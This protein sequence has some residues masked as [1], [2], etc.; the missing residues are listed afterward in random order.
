MTPGEIRARR[1]AREHEL[2]FRAWESWALCIGSGGHGRRRRDV[3]VRMGGEVFHLALRR[4]LPQPNTDVVLDPDSPLGVE[5]RE[6]LSLR[7][8]IRRRR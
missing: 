2:A 5:L 3:R 6:Y 4:A 8:L 7:S 1:L